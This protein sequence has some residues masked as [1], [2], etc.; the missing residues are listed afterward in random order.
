MRSAECT[1][2]SERTCRWPDDRLCR[3]WSTRSRG[4]RTRARTGRRPRAGRPSRTLRPRVPRA[5]H[6]GRPHR[7]ARGG[8]IRSAARS[9]FVG[10]PS[11]MPCLACGQPQLL[12]PGGLYRPD[13]TISTAAAGGT[14]R[15]RRTMPPAPGT[16]PSVTSGRPMAAVGAATRKR[17]TS[18]SMRRCV[19]SVSA[20]NGQSTA[21]K[22]C[23]TKAS[24]A[25][26]RCR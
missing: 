19:A 4:R 22:V 1:L 17:Q 24:A 7:R 8:S 26:D 11:T 16:R 21:E 2:V 25:G 14:K 13:V 12:R 23:A 20:G 15:G 5:P 18:A 6:R 9:F 3:S 10:A